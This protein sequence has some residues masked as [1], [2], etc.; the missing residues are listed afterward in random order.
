MALFEQYRRTLG[1]R[2][3][4]REESDEPGTGAQGRAADDPNG[5]SYQ[6]AA[7]TVLSLADQQ[8]L[9]EA[10]DDASRLRMERALL[11]RELALWQALPSVPD[12]DAAHV[13]IG[14]N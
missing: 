11:R 10:S 6:V 13:P 8:S 5:L 7:S 1:L 4:A 9:L 12:V 3:A 14:L 2:D